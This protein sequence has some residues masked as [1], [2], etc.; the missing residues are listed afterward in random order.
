M[1]YFE[2][3]SSY[4]QKIKRIANAASGSF[5]NFIRAA[6]VVSC[7]IQGSGHYYLQS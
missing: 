5:W 3:R 2:I 4:G 7:L 6:L 1:T